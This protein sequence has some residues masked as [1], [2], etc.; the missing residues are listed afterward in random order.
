M[1]QL[2][3]LSPVGER[4]R[5]FLGA[6]RVM[7]SFKFTSLFKKRRK[8]QR[9]LQSMREGMGRYNIKKGGNTE[10][11]EELKTGMAIRLAVFYNFDNMKE[12]LFT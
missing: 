4:Q 12:M 5:H 7:V 6:A 1:V 3:S 10:I 11:Q 2:S 8:L 9:V